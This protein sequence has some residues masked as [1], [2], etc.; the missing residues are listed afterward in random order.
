MTS[1]SSLLEAGTAPSPATI[2][3]SDVGLGSWSNCRPDKVVS[4]S[5]TIAEGRLSEQELA[6]ALEVL[7]CLLRDAEVEVRRVVAEQIKSSPLLPRDLAVQMAED[8]A[9]VAVP[10]LQSSP[11]LTDE[12][13]VMII[14][15]GEPVKQWAIAERESLSEAVSGALIDAGEKGVIEILLAN[16]GA[17]IS[18]SSLLNLLDVF[19]EDAM[20]KDLLVERPMLPFSVKE[21]LV[22]LVSRTLQAR[23]IERHALP[24]DLVE[25]IGHHGR[26][27]ALI[28]SLSTVKDGREIDAAVKRLLRSD[29]LTPTVL[30]R[31]LSA[32]LLEFFGA[33]LAI[34]ARVPS[35]RAQGALRKAGTPAL[36][37]LYERAQ[38]P[39]HLQPAFQI[40]FEVVLEHRRAGNTTAGSEVEN[41]IVAEMVEAYRKINPDS[42]DSVI[43]QLGRLS[44]DNP[45]ALTF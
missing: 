35:S 2:L 8:V 9:A 40:A 22:Y 28:E 11:V 14:A 15:L 21:R 41:R 30:L 12:D 23:L 39:S 7:R 10:I 27:R 16:D 31:G 45:D 19:A 17:A 6:V 3:P 32:G 25:Q 5:R 20:V 36:I 34:L 4:F 26:E 24:P 42:L 44:A 29:S 33:G 37:S 1:A 43:Y 13:L 38:L 18:E